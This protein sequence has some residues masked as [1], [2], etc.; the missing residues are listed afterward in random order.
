MR[1]IKSV[2]KF[3]VEFICHSAKDS[4]LEKIGESVKYI[5]S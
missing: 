3:L 2:L 1:V 5:L 4:F